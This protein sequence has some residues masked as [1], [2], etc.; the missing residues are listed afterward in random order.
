M[1][2]G[3]STITMQVIRLSKKDNKRNI[4][5]KLKE[6]ILAVRLELSYSKKN[7]LALYASNAPFGSNI[8]GLD[9]AA[10]RYYGRSADKLSWGEMATLA[11][12]PNAP[13]LVH[14]GRNRNVLLK[15]RNRLLDNLLADGKIDK[16]S[17]E[18]A[19]LESLP[20]EPFR[21]P[22]NASHL[23]QHIIQDKKE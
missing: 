4:W 17:A 8:V 12:L 21:L 5:N 11:V 13:A 2:Q 20:D 14:P 23:L 18:L 9:A 10:W 22:Q 6:S 1:V 15:K 7:I 19:K 16:A 3:G